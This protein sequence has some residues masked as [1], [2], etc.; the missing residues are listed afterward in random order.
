MY[1]ERNFI[2]LVLYFENT[3]MVVLSP[4]DVAY[5]EIRGV[6]EKVTYNGYAEEVEH[7][8]EAEQVYLR[9]TE[10]AKLHLL[11]TSLIPFGDWPNH[12]HDITSIAFHYDDGNIEEVLVPWKEEDQDGENPRQRNLFGQDGQVTILID[13]EAYP[14]RK[15][16]KK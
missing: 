8:K 1:R 10:K 14:F 9:L 4:A 11:K 16:A 12:F 2:G 13:S 6:K 15:E 7:E 5:L 3:D